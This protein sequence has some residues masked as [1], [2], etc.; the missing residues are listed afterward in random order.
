MAHEKEWSWHIDAEHAA[1]A[2]RG[3]LLGALVGAISL[4]A[5]L[6]G[7]DALDG[8]FDLYVALALGCN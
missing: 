1:I 4:A 6:V 5:T 7:V 3:G 2:R 8:R